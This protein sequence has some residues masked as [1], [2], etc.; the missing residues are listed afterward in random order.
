MNFIVNEKNK[1]SKIHM[2]LWDK[3]LLEKTLTAKI[4]AYRNKDY[5]EFL[6]FL[7]KQKTFLK[8]RILWM[9]MPNRVVWLWSAPAV[10]GGTVYEQTVKGISALKLSNGFF[11]EIRLKTEKGSFILFEAL[12][13]AAFNKLN[14]PRHI[15]ELDFSEKQ[16][17]DIVKDFNITRNLQSFVL[18]GSG[19]KIVKA[20]LKGPCFVGFNKKDYLEALTFK[21]IKALTKTKLKNYTRLMALASEDKE[22]MA[23]AKQIL[24]GLENFGFSS[25]VK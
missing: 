19:K 17:F 22:D 10:Y 14:M 24:K 21:D 23:K 6:K 13:A 25:V 8:T 4:K 20:N 3:Q 18:F 7:L 16:A 9:G 15:I 12:L 1:V 2:E 5:K 11:A